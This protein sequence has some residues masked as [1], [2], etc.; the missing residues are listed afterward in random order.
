MTD[1]DEALD[2]RPPGHQALPDARPAYRFPS[3]DEA[4]DYCLPCPLTRTGLRPI[5]ECDRDT[6]ESAIRG[7]ERRQQDGRGDQEDRAYVIVVC[8]RLLK[9]I[10]R[11]RLTR[12]DALPAY[13][14]RKAI[15]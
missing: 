3:V 4:L 14:I 1:T 10:K 5:G 2:Y 9:L 12:V 8:Q 15:R 6:L 11:Y 13:E 7:L